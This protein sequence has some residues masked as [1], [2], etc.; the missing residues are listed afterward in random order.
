MNSTEKAIKLFQHIKQVYETRY[1]VIT[2]VQQEQW[3]QYLDELP[4]SKKFLK[5]PFL[6]QTK[7]KENV[8]LEVIKPDMEPCPPIPDYLEVWINTDW[9]DPNNQIVFK[10]S[11]LKNE[12]GVGKKVTFQEFFK[13]AEAQQELY[14]WV[15]IRTKWIESRK[16]VK[17]QKRYKQLELIFRKFWNQYQSLKKES[18]EIVLGQGV[19]VREQIEYPIL[20]KRVTLDFDVENN[21]IRIIDTDAPS[22]LNVALLKQLENVDEKAINAVKADLEKSHPLAKDTRKLLEN[23]TYNL[24]VFAVYRDN[25]EKIE[26][27]TVIYNK[28]ILLVRE[29]VNNILPALDEIINEIK[30]TNM[31]SPPLQNM[32]EKGLLKKEEP[33]Q[34]EIP[35]KELSE[36][37][38]IAKQ[39]EQEKQ[40]FIQK[41]SIIRGEDKTMLLAKAANKEQIEIGHCMETSDVVVVQSP[42][43]TAKAHMIA[44]LMG[45]FLAEGNSVL[46][47]S[48]TQKALS[49]LKEKI[50]PELQ[51]LCISLLE[52][53]KDDIEHSIDGMMKYLSSHK[54]DKVYDDA[55]V[56]ERQR[57]EIIAS[58]QTVRN[59]LYDIQQKEYEMIP[60]SGEQYTPSEVA[61]FVC[62]NREE[63]SYIP[64]E[65]AIGVPLPVS[66]KSLEFLYQL[67][68]SMTREQELE[69][70]Y[71]LPNPEDFMSPETFAKN[72]AEKNSFMV[73]LI[74]LQG[75]IKDYVTVDVVK[76]T[77]SI[78]DTPLYNNLNTEK[79]EEIK[80]FFRQYPEEKK[81]L[82]WELSAISSA[83]QRQ[84]QKG[85]RKEELTNEWQELVDV[86][87]DA[88]EYH[89]RDNEENQILRKRVEF[90]PEYISDKNLEL[91]Y[92][93]REQIQQR[94]K[95]MGKLFSLLHKDIMYLYDTLEINGKHISSVADCDDLI[96]T[97]SMELKRKEI[98]RLWVKLIEEQDGMPFY[99]L[100]EAPEQEGIKMID[101]IEERLNWHKTVYEPIQKVALE[102]GLSPLCF[103]T[104]EEITSPIEEAE[105]DINLIYKLLPD[106]IAVAELIEVDLP[107]SNNVLQEAIQALEESKSQEFKTSN[108]CNNMLIAMQ[109]QDAERYE[110]AYKE[111]VA[112]YQKNHN[113]GKRSR[114]L[115][116]I[117]AV[118]PK[119]A[120]AIRNRQGIHG[121]TTCPEN[122]KGAWNWKQF[123]MIVDD[124]IKL[125]FDEMQ[126]QLKQLGS[127]LQKTTA[128]LVESKTW[129]RIFEEMKKNSSQKQIL[130][131][132]K[133]VV[134]EKGKMAPEAQQ[135]MLQCQPILPAWIMSINQVLEQFNP[136]KNKFDIAIIDE[137]NQCNLS[138]L[139]ILQMAKKVIVLGDKKQF[140]PSI[141]PAE[142]NIRNLIGIVNAQLYD[143]R[144]SLYDIAEARF[145]TIMLK[146]HFRSLPHII[147]YNNRTFYDNQLQP[148]RSDK[149]VAVKPATIS[150]RVKGSKD[151]KNRNVAEAK[152]IVALMLA[153]MEQPEYQNMTFG[154]ISLG[155]AEQAR[156][157]Q[158]LSFDKIDTKEYEQRQILCGEASYFQNEER[159][160]IFI[161]LVDN[162]GEVTYQ[163]EMRNYNVAVS[164]AKNQLWVVHSLDVRR[165][166]KP[167]DIRKDFIEYVTNPATFDQTK[168]SSYFEKAVTKALIKRG[169]HIIPKWRAG[170]F[171]IDMVAVY[172]DN[173]VAITC[174]GKKYE[175]SDDDLLQDMEKQATL[176]RA[177]WKFVR[178]RG[179]EYYNNPE[180]MLDRIAANLKELG[181]EPE[182]SHK[183]NFTD[184]QRK[185]RVRAS[186][187]I[188]EWKKETEEQ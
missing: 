172:Q 153:C 142:I 20:L 158:K 93:L 165:D 127:T 148:L 66:V 159:D 12:N 105:H 164:R 135:L 102:C 188:N 73:K 8:I 34:E 14:D 78:Q 187:I 156:L 59:T 74:T 151:S 65:I 67:N 23:L 130:Q 88:H 35:Q 178:I 104:P 108:I 103:E 185:V 162:D 36:E 181:I 87:Q 133:N 94:G 4:L 32:I 70:L 116:K 81:F 179:S 85:F 84:K 131:D 43:G 123:S 25:G 89:M 184:L 80:E 41:I 83:K 51:H 120:E 90:D 119:W 170:N 161:S 56:S 146:E 26:N 50:E 167:E 77:A 143:A 107:N 112:A 169:Y 2:N 122:I 40:E 68:N 155:G 39:K 125:P 46:V 9:K 129:S 61:D 109:E 22:E 24:N 27:E 31:V 45:H 38:Q 149:N 115:D 6:D 92:K 121:K 96:V 21:T 173:R 117:E 62:E 55:I 82:D 147:G 53:D 128:K 19:L 18:L 15:N 138:S 168:P 140:G 175:D 98:E 42:P 60:F 141:I 33:K 134:V 154:V 163:P 139:A 17:Q 52:S 63:M 29:K 132:W 180:Q 37:E 76:N 57:K 79:I 1:K 69:L 44:N 30:Q 58:L 113:Y 99:R 111:L 11:I 10:E 16:N 100:G 3:Y 106:Y 110:K 72:T 137:A 118:A 5:C 176:E 177:G 144:H 160:I 54:Y 49:T 101:Q 7:G 145:E 171:Y 97:M 126:K 13:D 166:L 152:N 186:Q 95:K 91:L 86:L 183:P 124:I 47:T 182:P 174:D 48:H 64:G 150:Y 157:I 71:G 75:K 136:A 28:P 114:I